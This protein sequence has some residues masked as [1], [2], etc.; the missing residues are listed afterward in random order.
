LDVLT[1]EVGEKENHALASLM[2]LI[3][4]SVETYENQNVPEL[5]EC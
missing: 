2:E 3:N 5:K 4:L 1:S